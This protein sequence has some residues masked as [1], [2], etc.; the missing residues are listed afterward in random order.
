M[1]SSVGPGDPSADWQHMLR[2]LSIDKP[3][4]NLRS[5]LD[6]LVRL[7]LP[8]FATPHEQDPALVSFTDGH[9]QRLAWEKPVIFKNQAWGC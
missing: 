3:C 7:V 2:L 6:N 5:V 1:V 8:H 4:F 9:W